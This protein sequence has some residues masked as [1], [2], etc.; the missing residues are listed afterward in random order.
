MEAQ[1]NHAHG[2][3]ATHAPAIGQSSPEDSSEKGDGGVDHKEGA[4]AFDPQSLGE[5][6]KKIKRN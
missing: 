2:H 6:P 1:K 4:Y 5:R 3:R